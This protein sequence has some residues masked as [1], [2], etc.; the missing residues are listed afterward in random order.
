MQTSAF[1]LKNHYTLPIKNYKFLAICA[2]KKKYHI[3]WIKMLRHLLLIFLRIAVI[4][5]AFILIF[6]LLS[7]HDSNHV[8]L[9]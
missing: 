4:N 3:K 5:N 1:S 6:V 7:L 2:S 8:D 9:S